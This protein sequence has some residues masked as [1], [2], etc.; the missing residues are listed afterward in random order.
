MLS[1]EQV[2]M[3]TTVNENHDSAPIATHTLSL[4]VALPF[5]PLQT[6]SP[7]QP[8]KVI[9]AIIEIVINRYISDIFNIDNKI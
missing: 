6:P 5:Y 9:I 7:E 4:L 3:V 1:L 2:P 8:V